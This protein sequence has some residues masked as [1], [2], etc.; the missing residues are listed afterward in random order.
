MAISNLVIRIN[1]LIF[2]LV[3]F[4]GCSQTYYA[5]VMYLSQPAE[6]IISES[7]TNKYIGTTPEFGILKRQFLFFENKGAPISL[8]F[9]K[10][11]YKEKIIEIKIIDGWKTSEEDAR[12]SSDFFKVKV[13]LEPH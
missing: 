8:K 7:Q 12:Q 2:L 9:E 5:H 11:G 1:I 3:S 4:S 10:I 13:L 6:A